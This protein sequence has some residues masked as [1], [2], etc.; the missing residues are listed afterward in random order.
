MRKYKCKPK[1]KTRIKEERKARSPGLAYKIAE[2]KSLLHRFSQ[3]QKMHCN[4]FI[5]RHLKHHSQAKATSMARAR[6]FCKER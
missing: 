2:G 4:G 3:E 5:A 1:K 6:G